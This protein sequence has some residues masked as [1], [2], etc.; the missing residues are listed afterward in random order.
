MKP[1]KKHLNDIYS[2]IHIFIIGASDIFYIYFADLIVQAGGGLF[3]ISP[4]GPIILSAGFSIVCIICTLYLVLYVCT[5]C[6]CNCKDKKLIRMIL[7]IGLLVGSVVCAI[8][9]FILIGI[10]GGGVL[11][12]GYAVLIVGLCI[13]WAIDMG[14]V[15]KPTS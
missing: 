3:Q 13:T 10:V 7:C 11:Y 9:Y 2:C 14:M 6:T 4:T 15:D 12:V 1:I 8:G 5:C